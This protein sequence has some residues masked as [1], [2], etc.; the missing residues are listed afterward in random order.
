MRR[1]DDPMPLRDDTWDEIDSRI[2]ESFANIA[3]LE[4]AP[5]GLKARVLRHYDRVRHAHKTL[6][7]PYVRI[8]N[9][10]L[11]PA[12]VL[13]S[14]N[15]LR[16]YMEQFSK[17]RDRT[18][19]KRRRTAASSIESKQIHAHDMGD[20]TLVADGDISLDMDLATADDTS[21]GEIPELGNA[22]PAARHPL[23]NADHAALRR[24]RART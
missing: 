17:L 1:V 4:R 8:A 11:K 15:T 24:A 16:I 2:E 9:E 6:G 19:T 18:P 14:P 5:I 23:D 21:P 20:D 7:W 13:I 12:G 3:K 22:A 10:L